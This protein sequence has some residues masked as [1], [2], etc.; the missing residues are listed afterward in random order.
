MAEPEDKAGAP[1]SRWD[2]IKV[3]SRWFFWPLTISFFVAAVSSRALKL[4]DGVQLLVW[5]VDAYRGTVYPVTD[6]IFENVWPAG[7]GIPSKV[8]LDG[9]L[10]GASASL[11]FLQYG[12]NQVLRSTGN[13]SGSASLVAFTGAPLTSAA[14][15]LFGALAFGHVLS[16]SSGDASAL[17]L[18]FGIVLLSIAAGFLVYIVVHRPKSTIVRTSVLGFLVLFAVAFALLLVRELNARA[19]TALPLLERWEDA[20]RKTLDD[21]ATSGKEMR[22]KP[23]E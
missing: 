17:A 12:S 23:T 10:I 18:Q 15:V 2:A 1:Q 9:F 20:T 19:E 3:L 21:F 5:L 14:F 8:W 4:I 16:Q 22:P 11:A 13:T 7:W 6:W